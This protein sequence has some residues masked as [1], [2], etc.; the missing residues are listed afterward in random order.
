MERTSNHRAAWLAHKIGAFMH[1]LPDADTRHLVGQMEVNA[2]AD[3]LAEAAADYFIF[4]FGQNTGFYNAPNPVFDSLTGY[5][6]GE[7]C[8][9]RDLVGEI[10]AACRQRGIRFMTYLPCQVANQDLRAA[11]ALGFPDDL[12]RDHEITRQGRDNW[13]KV[14]E[15]WSKAYG[16]LISGWWFDGAYDHLAFDAE[17]SI[18][19]ATAAKAGNP[20]AIC[21]FNGGLDTFRV[22]PG[23]DYT[24]GEIADAFAFDVNSATDHGVQAHCLTYLGDRW[25]GTN[26]RFDDGQLVE[27]ALR[28]TRKGCAIS[29]DMGYNRASDAAPLGTFSPTQFR[30]F[31][32]I[33]A[34]IGRR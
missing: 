32:A 19:Y 26:C 14:I 2:L 12:P 24:A 34:A 23:D 28:L 7:R 5:Q 4:T 11:R 22:L 10:A 17:T 9:T 33:C 3:Q 18:L 25:G 16:T 21:A 13:A 6:P 8:A 30:H 29:L 27:W 1:F 15:Y 31:K 20:N